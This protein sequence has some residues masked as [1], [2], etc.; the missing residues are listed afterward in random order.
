MVRE[1]ESRH[2]A[3]RQI[4]HMKPA[5]AIIGAI[6]LAAAAS[7]S[8][9]NRRDLA[10]VLR[11]L[12]RHYDSTASFTAKFG[13]EISTP[14]A[15]VRRRSG[16]V[17]FRKPGR[18]RWDFAGDE[19]ET[20]VSDG[21]TLYNYDPGLNQVLEMPLKSAFK[22]NSAT[23]FILGMGNVH[24]DFKAAFAPSDRAGG[25]IHLSLNPKEGGYRIEIA[26]DPKGYELE[27]VKFTDQLGNVTSIAFSDI[28]TNAAIANGRFAFKV[29]AGADIVTA[30]AAP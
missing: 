7:A 25:P 15:P 4:L 19:P 17:Y 2:S 1:I 13:E 8:A 29:P 14:G 6:L 30:P 26:V 28:H 5:T 18:M 24:R 10:Q 22:A 11:G 27:A 16:T 9:A 23:A 21:T 12:Q 3:M 20:I